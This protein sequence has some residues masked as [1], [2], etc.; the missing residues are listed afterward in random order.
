MSMWTDPG[1]DFIDVTAFP[2]DIVATHGFFARHAVVT[3]MGVGTATVVAVTGAGN[4]RTIVCTQNGEEL[5]AF[6]DTFT[7][8]T[9]VARIRIFFDA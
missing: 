3:D 6:I 9:T 2:Y 5:P 8:A 7:A 1:N 4:T